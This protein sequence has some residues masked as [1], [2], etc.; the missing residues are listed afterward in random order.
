MSQSLRRIALLACLPLLLA[1]GLSADQGPYQRVSWDYDLP[2]RI[3][4]G[5]FSVCSQHDCRTRV[6]VSLD[7]PSWARIEQLFRPPAGSAAE[8]RA[9]VAEAIG[10][11]ER[12]VADAADT[13]HDKGGD[14]N[15]FG[16]PGSQL[17][18]V[19]ESVNTT[20]YLTL[21]QQQGLLR[22]HR[23]VHRATRGYLIFGGWPHYTAVIEDR[24]TARAWVVDSWFRDNG[25]AADVLPVAE[26]REGWYPEG[27]SM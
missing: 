26:W 21:F 5:G 6:P 3:S 22:W 17:D 24:G 27:F 10:L 12:L 25:A 13:H 9:R 18:C 2:E 16:E 4:P 23:V 11:M 1:G 19:D 8:E 14:F 15:G 7:P 20:T